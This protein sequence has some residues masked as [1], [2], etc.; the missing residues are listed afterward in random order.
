[1]DIISGLAIITRFSP[2]F[3]VFGLVLLFKGVWSVYSSFSQQ[4]YFEIMGGIDVIAGASLLL[5]YYGI[6]REFFVVVGVFVILKGA[7]SYFLTIRR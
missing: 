2:L 5:M 4:F 3:L 1:M 6:Y 7:V